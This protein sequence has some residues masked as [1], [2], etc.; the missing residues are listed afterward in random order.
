MA[1]SFVEGILW[2]WQ[3]NPSNNTRS[4]STHG[5]L[6]M[7]NTEIRW[8]NILCRQSQRGPIQSA[9]ARPRAD[10]GSY[11][12]LLIAKFRLKVKKV[13]KSESEVAQLCPTLCDPMDC[14]LPGFSIHGI[15]QGRVLEWVAVSLSRGSSQPRDLIQ[16]SHIVGRHFYHLSHQER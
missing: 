14:S 7:I 5:R 9:K 3:T 15:F 16:V 12:E 4:N 1:D 6:Q 2:S 8:T 13:G 10:C 11:H